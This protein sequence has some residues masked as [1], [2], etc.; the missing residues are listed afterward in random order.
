MANREVNKWKVA[1]FILLAVIGIVIMSGFIW[2]YQTFPEPQNEDFSIRET[3]E[4][5]RPSFSISTSR[6]DLNL[7]L[8]QEL[9]EEEESDMYD[10][11]IDDAVYLETR[12]SAFGFEVPLEMKLTPHVTEEGNIELEEEYFQVS[13]INLPS[14][15]V[16]QMIAANVDLP[17]WIYVLAEDRK[18]YVNVRE[19]VSEDIDV[20]VQSFDLE[21]DDIEFQITFLD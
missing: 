19:G 9:E 6:E 17:E 10:M 7:W 11:Y 16:F 1:F 3:G 8:Q 15:R 12:L 20:R 4:Q 5:E 21:N 13:N 14:E 18:F 2:F